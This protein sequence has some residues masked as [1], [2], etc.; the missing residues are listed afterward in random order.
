MSEESETVRPKTRAKKKQNA[1]KHGVYSRE[2]M[3]PGENIRSYYAFAA[4]FLEE[5]APEG[6]TERGLV[7][8]LVGLN[9]RKQRL[10]RYEQTQLQAHVQRINETN[11]ASRVL[12]GLKDLIPK[13]QA[14]DGED[15]IR[16]L[17]S[18]ISEDYGVCFDHLVPHNESSGAAWGPAIVKF[19]ETLKPPALLEGPAKII[20]LVDPTHI[21]VG[22]ARSDRIDEA[23]DRTIKRLMQ[24]KTA[25]QIFPKLRNTKAEPKL[26][27]APV[28]IHP[29]AQLDENEQGVELRGMVEV[30][31]KPNSVNPQQP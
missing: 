11:E 15:S 16:E 29:S 26:I 6:P 4:E 2:V 9:W 19:L 5:W 23:I 14:A 1:L 17:F 27:N 8:R 31:A 7:E 24:V 18:K 3:L 13:F 28:L 22:M 30:F 10:D 12:Q 21:Q 20:A 25:K